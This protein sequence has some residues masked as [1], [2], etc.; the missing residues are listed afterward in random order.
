MAFTF[1][2]NPANEAFG[3]AKKVG[4]ASDYLEDRKARLVY[5]KNVKIG[6]GYKLARPC[7]RLYIAKSYE[8]IN[9]FRRGLLIKKITQ[10]RVPFFNNGDLE[11][12]LYT[13]E[14]LNN[15]NV[16]AGT[17]PTPNTVLDFHTYDLDPCGQ[18]FGNSQ[19]G[20][21]NFVNYLQL[22]T[23]NICNPAQTN[24]IAP[25]LTPACKINGST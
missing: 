6:N 1:N 3:K 18:L 15:V 2:S 16:I 22:N 25:A 20:V 21:G 13:K 11:I 10:G 23:E 5:C 17:V 14:N 8:T 19:C 4:Y 9:L 7:D 24:Y 12:N